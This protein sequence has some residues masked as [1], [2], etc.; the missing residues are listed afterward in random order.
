MS[1]LQRTIP[2]EL[3]GR[4]MSLDWLSSTAAAPVGYA[5]V[6]LALAKVPVWVITLTGAALRFL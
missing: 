6:G 1:A 5:L 4:V 3:L 2:D